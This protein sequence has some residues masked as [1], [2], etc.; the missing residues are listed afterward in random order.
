MKHSIIQTSGIIVLSVLLF[1]SC[2]GESPVN[3]E[4]GQE[5]VVSADIVPSGIESKASDALITGTDKPSFATDDV[6]LITQEGGTSTTQSN[7]KSGGTHWLPNG[8]GN[9]LTTDGNEYT[10]TAIYPSDF[11]SILENQDVLTNTNRA[12]NFAKSDK[13]EAKVT[14]TSNYIPFKFKHAFTKITITVAYKNESQRKN[15]TAQ[16]VGDG[17]RTNELSSQTIKMLRTSP[18]DAAT[19]ATNHTFIC[20]LYPGDTRSFVLTVNGKTSEGSEAAAETYTQTAN[21]FDPGHNY[22]YNFSSNNNLILNS[23][24]VE[25]FPLGDQTDVGSAT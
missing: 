1:V 8:G 23:V 5:L 11:N 14:T 10:Y 13:L 16:L 18:S 19:V 21:K 22:I 25:E 15:V 4:A 6:I 20:I 7:Y 24:T 3:G 17:I 9:G 12:E 2:S